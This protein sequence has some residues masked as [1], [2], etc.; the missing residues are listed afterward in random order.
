[1]EAHAA[2][3]RA[4]LALERRQILEVDAVAHANDALARAVARGNAA[5][6]G[7]A[8]ELGEKR[9]LLGQGVGFR[10]IRFG[11]ETAALEEASD[12]PGDLA[13]HP[14]DLR[15][16]GRRKGME[17]KS[18]A[19]PRRVDAVGKQ[20]V[21]VDVQV[22]SVPEALHEGDRAALAAGDAPTLARSA[23]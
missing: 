15:I 17:A 14:L 5:G 7:G 16:L 11:A 20:R 22:E 8:V 3:A 23:P 10:G 19:R 13:H 21:E 4:T 9:L 2:H 12:A 18:P 1:M 6:N